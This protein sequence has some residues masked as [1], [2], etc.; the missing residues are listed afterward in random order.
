MVS[1]V[2]RYTDDIHEVMIHTGQHYDNEMSAIFFD[3]LEISYPEY[4]LDIGS[5]SHGTQTGRMLEAVE[6][7][8]IQEKPDWVLVYGDTNSTLA[9]ALAAVKLHIPVAHIEAGLRSFNRQMPEEINRV[10]TDHISELLFV[11]TKTALANLIREGIQENRVKLV[12]DIMYDAALFFGIKAEK[13]SNILERLQL[14]KKG[15]ILATVHRAENTNDYYRLRAIFEGLVEV[16]GDIK[17]VVPLHPR[18]YY[19]LKRWNLL[20]K[21]NRHLQLIEPVGYLDMIMLEKNAL[22]IATDSGGVQKEAYF[23]KIPCITLRNETEWAELLELGWNKLC[24][25][26]SKEVIRDTIIS[27][28]NKKGKNNNIFGNGMAGC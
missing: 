7:V 24:P 1:R 2:L 6:R 16:A 21:A 13:K 26:E 4:N 11:P 23:Y 17:I 20:E 9:G 12:G 3:E 25:P 28:I 27:F 5:A 10:L 19:A 8:L 18:T 15:Y 22:M 14:S